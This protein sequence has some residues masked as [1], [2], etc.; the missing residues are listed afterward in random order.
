[1]GQRETASKGE[2]G[3]GVGVSDVIVF[4]SP[5]KASSHALLCSVQQ[6]CLRGLVRAVGEG[7]GA[8]K[9]TVFAQAAG[10]GCVCAGKEG[11]R[12]GKE[13]KMITET[14]SMQIKG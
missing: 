1:M 2:G 5:A 7:G 13:T 10:L 9:H 14:I 12:E 6:R 4:G 11:G 3:K 8:G